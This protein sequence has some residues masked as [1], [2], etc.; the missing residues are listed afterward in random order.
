MQIQSYRAIK[1][2]TH[3]KKII[4]F[5]IEGYNS[6]TGRPVEQK[7]G[8]NDLCTKMNNLTYLFFC[9]RHNFFQAFS[10]KFKCKDSLWEIYPRQ[11]QVRSEWRHFCRELFTISLKHHTFRNLIFDALAVEWKMWTFWLFFLIQP[12]L[13]MPISRHNF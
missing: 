12:R 1:R 3:G 4:F 6:R 2:P 7:L 13:K 5:K 10:Q 9:W 8:T 11:R